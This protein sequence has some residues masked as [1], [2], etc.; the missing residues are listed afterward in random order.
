MKEIDIILEKAG[1]SEERNID[2]TAILEMYKKNSYNYYELQVDFIKK[3]GNLEIHYKHPIWEEDIVIR[4]NPI[5]AQKALTMDVVEEYN[6]FLGDELLII[7]DIDKENITLFMS[8]RGEF[9]GAYDDCII[10]WGNNFK[11]MLSDLFRGEKGEI[12]IM[13]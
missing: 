12:Q 1:F 4:L 5:E 7:G 11:K 2:T 6:E 3:Y 13:D 10:K 8:K 9:Y